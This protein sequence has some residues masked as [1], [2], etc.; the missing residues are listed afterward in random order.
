MS[1]IT[2]IYGEIIDKE[3]EKKIENIFLILGFT[4]L[5]ACLIFAYFLV[6]F[7]LLHLFC[8]IPFGNFCQFLWGVNVNYHAKFGDPSLKNDSVMPILIIFGIWCIPI[9]YLYILGLEWKVPPGSKSPAF[10]LR[11]K[12]F[13]FSSSLRS[14]YPSP[15][16]FVPCAFSN[17]H[18]ASPISTAE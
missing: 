13:T 7:L 6:T 3:G 9:F 2:N 16:I 15:M 5:F 12:A 14:S 1:V 11:I 17:A 18:N 10:S 8:H 4:Y